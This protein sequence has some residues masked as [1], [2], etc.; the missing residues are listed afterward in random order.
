MNFSE[1]EGKTIVTVS[2]NGDSLGLEFKDGSSVCLCSHSNIWL[3]PTGGPTKK[4]KKKAVKT[5]ET[6]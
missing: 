1:L 4:T 6:V 5:R 3:V 2:D